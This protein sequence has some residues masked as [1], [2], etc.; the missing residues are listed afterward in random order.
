MAV[1]L[2][3]TYSCGWFIMVTFLESESIWKLNTF[4][5]LS[6]LR[7]SV[8]FRHAT[9]KLAERSK[10]LRCCIQELGYPM[11]EM[12][13]DSFEYLLENHGTYM[14]L[15]YIIYLLKKPPFSWLFSYYQP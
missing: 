10:C 6:E 7:G 3:G 12:D 14:D 5:V 8:D 11:A 15:L 2:V 1:K 9:K 4:M 13:L